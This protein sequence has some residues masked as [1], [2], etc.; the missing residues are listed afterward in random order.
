MRRKRGQHRFFGQRDH[1]DG[2]GK[3]GTTLVAPGQVKFCDAAAKYC[4]DIHLLAT[5]Q[6]TSAGTATYKFRPGGGSHSYKAV[7]LGTKSYASSNSSASALAVTGPY[8]TVTSISK[9][10]NRG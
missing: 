10:Q 5:A 2:D 4:T 8:P 7:F 9:T 3:A 6:L 1:T